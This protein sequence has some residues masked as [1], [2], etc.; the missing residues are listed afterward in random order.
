MPNTLL[1][2][3]KMILAQSEIIELV[4]KSRLIDGFSNNCLE[5]AGYD[6]R[7]GKIYKIKSDSYLGENE[8]KTPEIE[9]INSESYRLKPSEYVLIETVEKVNMPT[10]LIARILPRSTIFRSGCFLITAVVDPG[11]EGTLTMG[12]KNVSGFNFTIEKKSR[13]AQI[14]FEKV[15]GK[16]KPYS[17]KYQGG[18]VV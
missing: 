14:I 5:G 7:V 16:T 11:F 3:Q 15:E 13:V 8:R 17:G 6:L 10:N 12:L 18:K 9:E 4:K 1:S 2:N